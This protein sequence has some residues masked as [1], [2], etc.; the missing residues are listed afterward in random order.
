MECL[1]CGH[2]FTNP[3][4]SAGAIGPY[5]KSEDYV[6]H[7]DTSKGLLFTLY[8]S[9]KSLTLKRKARFIGSLS[10]HRSLLDYG[11]GSGDFA[12]YMSA[13]H[14]SVTAFEPDGDARGLIASKY[15]QVDIASSL[16]DISDSSLGV[17]TL[18]HVLEHV[19][20]LKDTIQHFHRILKEDGVLIIA[21]PNCD[22]YDASFYGAHWAAY[23]VPRHIYHFR[24]ADMQLL[25]GQSG[26]TLTAMHPMWFDSFYVC[27]LSERYLSVSGKGLPMPLQWVRA[28]LVGL[29]SNLKAIQATSVCS[30][31]VYVLKKA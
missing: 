5:Y 16:S 18:W 21:V 23:D 20:F 14:Y 25:F 22:S 30:S 12:G 27:L 11:A 4:P 19:H 28:G 26:F 1:G 31:V 29:Y 2:R 10:Q 17:I 7:N 15:P 8:Q 9:V 3:R 6:S 24:P 13:Q